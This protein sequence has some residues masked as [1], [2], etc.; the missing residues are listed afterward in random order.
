VIG[1][2]PAEPTFF[3]LA[4]QGGYGFQM[5]LGAAALLRDR[6]AG[7]RPALDPTLVAALSPDR[8]R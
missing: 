3:W 1:P 6:V 8:L 2:D 7:V 5:S 4:G